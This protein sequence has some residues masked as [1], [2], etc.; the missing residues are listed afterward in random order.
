MFNSGSTVNVDITVKGYPLVSNKVSYSILNNDLYSKI[1]LKEIQV[2]NNVLQHSENIIDY[3]NTLLNMGS[4][5]KPQLSISIRGNP[6][7][8]VD[9]I[10][11]V[12]KDGV[13]HTVFPISCSYNYS[14]GLSATLKCVDASARILTDTCFI[15]PGMVIDNIR[16]S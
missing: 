7:I 2:D 14:E 9:D 10:L 1:G 8:E 11:E 3:A 5:Y 6:L 15:A 12:E 13:I 4:S 16:F